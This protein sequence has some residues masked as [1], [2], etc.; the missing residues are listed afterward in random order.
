VAITGVLAT[1]LSGATINTDW[2]Y[3]TQHNFAPSS[4][5]GQST[6][7]YHGET[8]DESE[9]ETWVSSFVEGGQTKTGH[10]GGIFSGNCTRITYKLYVRNSAGR[11]K[12]VTMFFS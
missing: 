4:V 8:D 9:V 10:F 7:Q 1:S 11:A 3:S 12:C 5:W 2:T 6:L